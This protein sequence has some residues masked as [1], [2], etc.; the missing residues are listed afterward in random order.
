MNITPVN[1]SILEEI[2]DRILWLAIKMVDHSNR[3]RYQKGSPKLG[4]HQASSASVTT[5]MTYLF[6]E[7]MGPHDK[8]SIKPHA[9]PVFHAVQYLLNQLD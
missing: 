2:Q 9:A 5:I 3:G 6:F 1:N 8:I 7:F 4:G